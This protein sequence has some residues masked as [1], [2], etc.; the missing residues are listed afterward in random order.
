MPNNRLPPSA[1][2]QSTRLQAAVAAADVCS[3]KH[4]IVVMPILSQDNHSHVRLTLLITQL[5]HEVQRWYSH[6][7]Y[8]LSWL[9]SGARI[10]S[11]S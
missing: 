8:T 2:P 9:E 1:V 3:I 4:T 10:L 6:E 5:L 11:I 7:N